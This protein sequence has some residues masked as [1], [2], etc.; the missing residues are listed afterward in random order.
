[1]GSPA[2]E[3]ITRD[4]ALAE[5]QNVFEAR[6]D[7]TAKATANDRMSQQMAAFAQAYDK[8]DSFDVCQIATGELAEL[9]AMIRTLND[10]R[11]SETRLL[12]QLKQKIMD[13]YRPAITRLETAREF[14]QGRITLFLEDQER[15]RQAEERR[16]AE[17]R[18]REQERIEREAA[19][20]RRQAEEAAAAERRKAE[21]ARQRAEDE[22]RARERAAAEERRKAEDA[23][24][25]QQRQADE[26]R[27]QGEAAVAREAEARAAE[28]RREAEERQRKVD[29]EAQAQR[30]A[31]AHVQTE[32]VERAARIEEDGRVEAMQ[33]Q[34]TAAVLP[35]PIVS[36]MKLE[37]AHLSGRWGAEIDQ[38]SNANLALELAKYAV[39]HPE[40]ANVVLP[41]WPV[42]NNL[43]NVRRERFAIPGLQARRKTSV[44]NRGPRKGG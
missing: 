10:E 32:S 1:M 19:E 16:L 11:L 35:A 36:D 39:A 37:G 24:R 15:K 40:D 4:E 12:D 29:E 41:N 3:V 8:I 42:L 33:I 21:E 34:Q 18:R 17:E 26:A 28:I 43:A 7:L 25:E 23:A 30:A 9:K 38:T 5:T 20:R 14:L 27:R 31:A 2:A 13:R 6:I 44:T 22:A